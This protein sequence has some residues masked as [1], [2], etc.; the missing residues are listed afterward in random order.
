MQGEHNV[1][2]FYQLA[3]RSLEKAVALARHGRNGAP[4]YGA[5]RHYWI[6]LPTTAKAGTLTPKEIR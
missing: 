6:T 2:A 1:C 5:R 3:R 4:A